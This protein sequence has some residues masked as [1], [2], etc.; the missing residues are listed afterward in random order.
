[1][2]LTHLNYRD[3]MTSTIS[4]VSILKIRLADSLEANGHRN[5]NNCRVHDGR[6]TSLR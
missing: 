4:S 1:M 2:L 6:Y 5:L 3:T